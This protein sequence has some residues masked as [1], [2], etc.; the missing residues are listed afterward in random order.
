M[1][2]ELTLNLKCPSCGSLTPKTLTE[3]KA[4]KAFDCECGFHADLQT[5]PMVRPTKQ[6]EK[7]AIPA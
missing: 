6:R 5:Q 1:Q 2:A 4:Q 7:I 3:I